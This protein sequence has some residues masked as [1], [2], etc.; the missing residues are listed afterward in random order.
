VGRAARGL[1]RWGDQRQ[2]EV[3]GSEFR[4]HREIRGREI[5]VLEEIAIPGW[6]VRGR[7]G[8]AKV[9]WHELP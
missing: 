9:E 4:R 1:L 2:V 8:F 5:G 6:E 7:W 3:R